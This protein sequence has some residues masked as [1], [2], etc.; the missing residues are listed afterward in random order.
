M[1]RYNNNNNND[2]TRIHEILGGLSTDIKYIKENSDRTLQKVEKN[3]NRIQSLEATRL[4][5][6]GFVLALS[7]GAGAVSHKIASVLKIF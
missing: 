1:A 7:T 3:E 4:K 6:Y 2:L 5:F